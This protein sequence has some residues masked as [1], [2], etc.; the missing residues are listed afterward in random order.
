MAFKYWCKCKDR[1]I[2]TNSK[3]Y[4]CIFC[5]KKLYGTYKKWTGLEPEEIKHQTFSF[6]E[7][8][9]TIRKFGGV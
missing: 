4:H 3:V 2:T 1:E 9:P 8:D 5:G 7:M 6:K